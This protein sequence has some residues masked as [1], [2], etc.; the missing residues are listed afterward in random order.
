MP[1]ILMG[2]RYATPEWWLA[3]QGHSGLV[4]LEHGR[5]N[6]VESVWNPFFREEVSRVL[7]ELAKH[8]L[9][10]DVIESI[11]PGICGDYGE[12]IFPVLGNWP[13]AYHTHR[14]FW[15]GGSDAAESFRNEMQCRYGSIGS[16]NKAWRASYKSFEKIMPFLRHRAPSRTAFMD[17]MK[18]YRGAM[19]EYSQFWMQECRRYFPE[20]PVYLCTGGMEEPEHGSSFAGQA[21]AAAKYKGGIRLTNE[22]NNFYDNFYLTAHMYSACRFY[23]AYMGLEPVGPMLPQGVVARTFGSV[24]YGNRQIFHYYG[25]LVKDGKPTGAAESVKKYASLIG[26]RETETAVAFFWPLD[27]STIEGSCIPENIKKALTFVRK[28]YEVSVLGEELILDGA[29]NNVKLLVMLDVNFT[30]G[31]VLEKIAQWVYEGGSLLVNTRTV[32]IEGIPAK[33]FDKIFGIEETSEEVWGHCEYYPD[34]VP[35]AKRFNTVKAIHAERGWTGLSERVVPI[36]RSRPHMDKDNMWI[37][38]VTCCFENYYGSGR[39]IYFSPWLHLDAQPDAVF[40]P[41]RAFEFL[42]TDCCEIF[43]G[44]HELGTLENGIA[45]TGAGGMYYV[46]SNDGI[47]IKHY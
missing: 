13:G 28:H 15:C 18:W 5:E 44:H 7:E 26:E 14:G 12:A 24:A 29:L 45:R 16:L 43:T 34:G 8:Y 27:Q 4:C 46:L 2:P 37:G 25:N 30:R 9:P 42:L 19:D 35:W 31:D 6:P 11:Q 20:T 10:W 32:D 17:L 22:G 23:G 3:D 21:K 41:S 40:T 38:D 39:G 1:F 47:N 33:S 36:A